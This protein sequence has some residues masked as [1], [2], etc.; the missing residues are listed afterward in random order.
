LPFDFGV[1][2]TPTPPTKRFVYDLEQLSGGEKSIASLALQY[3]L[4]ITS[5]APFFILD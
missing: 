5:N 1:Y 3:A 2:F 4:A